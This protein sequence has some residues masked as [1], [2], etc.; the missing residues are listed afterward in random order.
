VRPTRRLRRAKRCKRYVS[1]GS[2]RR[3]SAAGSSSVPFSGRIGKKALAPGAY[4]LRVTA[5]D[6][7]GNKSLPAD[8]RFTVVRR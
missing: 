7:A 3:M 5:T 8:A 1:A 6:A 4:R 2:F